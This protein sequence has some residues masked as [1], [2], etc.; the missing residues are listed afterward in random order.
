ME[1]LVEFVQQ[2]VRYKLHGSGL[3]LSFFT[4]LVKR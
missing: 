4:S 1:V 2:T 3:G